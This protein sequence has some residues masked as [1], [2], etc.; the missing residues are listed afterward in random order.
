MPGKVANYTISS[1]LLKELISTIIRKTH[2]AWWNDSP[3]QELLDT[4][5]KETGIQFDS[6]PGTAFLKITE[7]NAD[8]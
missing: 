6:I 5:S 3:V 7:P 4:I 8:E 2:G 1:S